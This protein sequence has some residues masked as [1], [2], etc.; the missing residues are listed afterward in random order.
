MQHS[1]SYL[2][3][4]VVT[5]PESA[6]LLN[7]LFDLSSLLLVLC[8]MQIDFFRREKA[9]VEESEETMAAARDRAAARRDPTLYK[10]GR[11]K[12]RV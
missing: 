2:R 3:V 4:P 5:H 6:P 10:P 11:S 8:S 1:N 9:E 7:A 12:L